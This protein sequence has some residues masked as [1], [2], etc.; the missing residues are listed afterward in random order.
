MFLLWRARVQVL[1]GEIPQALWCG[2]PTPPKKS[3]TL[4]RKMCHVFC[5]VALPWFLLFSCLLVYL[6]CD[7]LFVSD[8]T[9]LNLNL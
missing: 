5:S 6:N 3:V 8:G 2:P 7:I 9:H 1:V 4:W